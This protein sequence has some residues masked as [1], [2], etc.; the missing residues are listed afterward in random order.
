VRFVRSIL[1]ADEASG[2]PIEVLRSTM[3]TSLVLAVE[4]ENASGSSDSPFVVQVRVIGFQVY[5]TH[6]SRRIRHRPNRNACGR[7]PM[8]GL[9]ET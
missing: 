3:L 8:M 6:E 1:L 2:E 5:T 9:H 7:N 4:A